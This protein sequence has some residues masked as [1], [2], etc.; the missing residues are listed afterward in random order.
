MFKEIV[1]ISF[2]F[3]A[4]FDALFGLLGLFL[5][6]LYFSLLHTRAQYYV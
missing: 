3:V 5:G 2:Q 1:R 6:H 4:A